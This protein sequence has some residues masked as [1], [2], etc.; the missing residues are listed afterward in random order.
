MRFQLN[1][2]G[3]LVGYLL[4][5]G[6]VPL[7]VYGISAFQVARGIVIAQASE[8]N[9]RLAADV[10]T[11]LQ[12][13]RSQV[14]DLAASVAGNEAIA[15]ALHAADQQN[16][17]SFDRLN[18]Q[19]QI[20]YL[21]NNFV[22]VK[23]LV[24]IDLF[25]LKGKH[26][27]IGDTLDV[28][29][30][31]LD[32]VQQMIRDSQTNQN[33]PFWRGVENNVNANST[34]QKVIVL[35]RL[36]G[37]FDPDNGGNQPAG[38]LVININ[39]TIFND[40]FRGQIETKGIRMMAS[41][42]HGRLMYHE[43]STLIGLPLTPEL[44]RLARDAALTH[45]LQLDGEEV[46]VT[47]LSLP[48]I[49]GH[50]I[51]SVPLALQTAPV[52]RLAVSGL[53]SLMICLAGIAWLARHYAKT[54]VIPLR[55]V[56]AGFSQLRARP[57]AVHAP[58]HVPQKQDEI[59]VLVTGFNALVESITMQR[60]AND[61]LKQMEQSARENAHILRAAIEALD[62]AFAVFDEQDKLLFCNEQFRPL[63]TTGSEWIQGITTFEDVIRSDAK[64]GLYSEAQGRLSEW[65][66]ERLTRHRSGHTDQEQR[67]S[68]GRW[69]RLVERKMPNGHTV[70]FAMNITALK[71]LHEA[72]QAANSAKSAFL[73]NMSHEIRTPMNAILG[74]AHLLRLEGISP[75][76]KDHFD[77]IDIA[78][79]HLLSSINA[80]LDLS[81]IEA[82]KFALE[83]RPVALNTLLL[84]VRSILAERAT[85]RGI[86][87]QIDTDYLP[88]RLLGDPMRLQQALLNYATNAIKF[89]E[90]GTV[91]LR[92]RLH[93][94][95]D[96]SIKVRFEVEDTG[97][98]LTPET[99]ARLFKPFEQAD[100]SMTR[101]YGGTGL[102]LSITQRLAE[103]MG[104]SAGANSTLGVGS[105][106]WFTAQLKRDLS[107]AA[108]FLAQVQ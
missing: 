29:E 36:I 4:V 89:T 103:L 46:I 61:K 12:L 10:A 25:S 16:L 53:V 92:T 38:L 64:G 49:E 27:H 86:S 42:R 71:S 1:I 75:K 70:S 60:L 52:N 87:F 68:D 54:V 78:A 56:S 66:E 8:Y 62:A 106:F 100:N 30:L 72:A 85:A 94:E 18:T 48:H 98:G 58:L 31:A 107:S 80:I 90:T 17:S 84:N 40:Y 105:T 55:E 104:G 22:R 82:G 51:F 76:Q 39:E 3:K 73:A 77:K 15:N 6:I 9:L 83:E 7:L 91:T 88:Q 97:I 21:L 79:Q 19:A 11:Y 59:A 20:G 43:N 50:L 23:G 96:K 45:Q 28:S 33:G 2:T 99:L 74:M 34:H 57:N 35:T 65:V 95:T 5:A 41:D 69:L 24:S 81:K 93:A 44:L 47:T 102:G 14:E 108:D 32:V 37:Y 26:F 13:Y 67:L 63:N 101:K